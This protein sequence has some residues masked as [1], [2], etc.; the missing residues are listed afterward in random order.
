M[1]EPLPS[2]PYDGADVTPEDGAQDVTQDPG[3][4]YESEVDDD[5]S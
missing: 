5:D 2:T 4:A 1:A 3:V